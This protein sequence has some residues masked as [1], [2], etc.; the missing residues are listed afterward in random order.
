[1]KR[2]AIALMKR[3]KRR[4]KVIVVHDHTEDDPPFP[5]VT[6]RKGESGDE[7][8]VGRNELLSPEEQ[9]A[10]RQDKRKHAEESVADVVAAFQAG[11]ISVM[12]IA[13]H[14]GKQMC[15]VL[16]RAKKAERMGLIKLVKEAK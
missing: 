12:A 13:R 5:A 15:E 1:M 2:G 14:M 10:E 8:I 16:S 9:E 11:N 4:V 7:W 3:S 6:V